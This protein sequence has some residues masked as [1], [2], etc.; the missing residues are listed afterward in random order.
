M[1]SQVDLQVH[2]LP[3]ALPT[4]LTAEGL[5]PAVDRLVALQVHG[6][7]EGFRADGALQRLQPS[8]DQLVGSESRRPREAVP[9]KRALEELPIHVSLHV[10]PQVLKHV[11]GP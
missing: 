5:L 11:E 10:A 8:V 4:E 7:P 1:G 3:E 9:T 2:R 6:V